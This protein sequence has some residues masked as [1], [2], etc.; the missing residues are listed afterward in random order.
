MHRMF[1]AVQVGIIGAGGMGKAHAHELRKLDGVFSLTA[2]CD[3]KLE[4]AQE[5]TKGS[6]AKAVDR[7]DELL[8]S[9]L[10]EAVI[11]AAPHRLHPELAT[12]ALS[13]GLH[14]FVEKPLAVSSTDARAMIAAADARP[15]LQFAIGLNQRTWPV[16]RRVKSLLDQS[17][18][19]PLVRMSWTITDWFR[20][21]A[22]FAAS[23]WRGTWRGE[24]GGLLVN[25]CPH[26]LDLLLWFA[27]QHPTA[28]Q[29]VVRL[30]KHHAIETED[31]VHALIEFGDQL[32]ATFVASTG[33]ASSQNLLTLVGDRG[34]IV[35]DHSS[36]LTLTQTD[37]STRQ[38]IATSPHQKRAPAV[39]STTEQFQPFEDDH[40]ELLEHFAHAIR[41]KAALP[42]HARQG[43]ASVELANAILLS[44]VEGK[45]VAFPFDTAQFDQIL[46]RLS[47]R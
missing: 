9:E 15:D 16:W 6:G 35:V 17:A 20:T 10:V 32:T 28:V 24:G 37:T 11:I 25:Q 38:H 14:V 47:G 21:Q 42:L 46:A 31:E 41:G 27:G 8:Q 12:K 23:S 34:T 36:T 5:L 19:G 39:T 4:A 3:P 40:R 43:L 26:N 33:E 44:G 1:K 45:R 18:I 29:S 7:F 22:Y 30:G 2:V 13:A